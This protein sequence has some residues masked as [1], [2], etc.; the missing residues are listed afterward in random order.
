MDAVASANALS[1][2]GFFLTLV[3]LLGSFF[4]IHLGDWLRE[5]TALKTKWDLNKEGEQPERCA[6]RRECRYEI[7]HV[8]IQTTRL[9][10]QVVTGF[11]ILIFILGLI[12]WVAQPERDVAWICVAVAGAGF[13]AIYLGMINHLWQSGSSTARELQKAVDDYFNQHPDE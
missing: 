5:V 8:D 2:I 12:L 3:S 6:A 13:I 4:Y 1:V 7:G 9:T 10:S 11:V